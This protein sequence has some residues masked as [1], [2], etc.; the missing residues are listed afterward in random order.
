MSE[1]PD[2]GDLVKL[3]FSPRKG[4]EQRGWRPALVLSPKAYHELSN[5]AIVCP[6]TSNTSPW[7]MKVLLP[8]ESIVSGAILV[9]QIITIDRKA[10]G[11]HRIGNVSHECL[12]EVRAKLGALIML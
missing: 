1:L 8:Q 7:S 11:L 4:H 9:D 5:T 12:N 10:R 6:I 2:A 3:D